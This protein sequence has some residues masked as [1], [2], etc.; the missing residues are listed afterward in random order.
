MIQHMKFV[1]AAESHGY[2]V[3]LPVLSR[4]YLEKSG[5][6]SSRPTEALGSLRDKYAPS[7][8]SHV[9]IWICDKTSEGSHAEAI[10]KHAWIWL[11]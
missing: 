1:A 11:G 6:H 5:V 8:V 9:P 10:H 3:S 2:P 4:A 7:H